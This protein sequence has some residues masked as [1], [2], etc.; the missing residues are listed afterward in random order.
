MNNTNDKKYFIEAQEAIANSEVKSAQAMRK[1][2]ADKEKQEIAEY[3][4][5]IEQD[6]A[7]MSD[8]ELP[9]VQRYY[10]EDEKNYHKTVIA[11]T[12]R[13]MQQ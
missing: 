7:K 1:A 12:R 9:M 4:L 3:A 2:K 10:S 11:I 6:V 8:E 13:E 5:L